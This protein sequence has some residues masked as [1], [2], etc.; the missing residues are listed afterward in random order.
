MDKVIWFYEHYC[1]R[2]PRLTEIFL[3]VIGACLIHAGLAFVKDAAA[4]RGVGTSV[5]EQHPTVLAP[6]AASPRSANTTGPGSPAVSGDGNT[7]SSK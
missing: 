5:K 4:S 3:I 7:V 6:P 1:A 2:H